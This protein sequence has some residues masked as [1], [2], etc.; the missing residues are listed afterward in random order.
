MPEYVFL[1]TE[2]TGLGDE[3]QLVEIAIV[4]AA[5]VVLFESYCSPTVAVEAEAQAVHGIGQVTLA[6]APSW[7]EI[8]ETV[9]SALEGRTVVIFNAAF[10]T[11]ILRQTGAAHGFQPGWMATLK[12]ECAMMRAAQLYGATNKY[13]TISLTNAT[14]R[15]GIE[16][17]GRVH[18]AAG[19][20]TTTA[21]LWRVMTLS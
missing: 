9:R 15:A 11:R 20:A 10:D 2:T 1:D 7:P 21:A 4:D 5:G 12:T 18:S 3:A 14:A 8:A 6:D 13:G 16:F 17:Q 19:D